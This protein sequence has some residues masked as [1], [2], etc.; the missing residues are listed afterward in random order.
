MTKKQILKQLIAIGKTGSGR[1]P[2]IVSDLVHQDDL[3]TI[4][5][6]LTKLLSALATDVG[7][8]GIDAI[9][10]AFPYV[11]SEKPVAGS[12]AEAPG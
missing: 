2:F 8:D 9:I 1:N 5:E 11:F 12:P 6:K 7:N 4:Q 3:F 10:K